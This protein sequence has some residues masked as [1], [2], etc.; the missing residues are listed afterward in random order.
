MIS[1][2]CN[3]K[4]Y[5]AAVDRF[6]LDPRGMREEME[7]AVVFERFFDDDYSWDQLFSKHA[8]MDP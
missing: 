7:K 8:E 6:H 1:V 3:R 2:K 5:E 4:E